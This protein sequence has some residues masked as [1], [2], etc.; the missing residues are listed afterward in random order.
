MEVKDTAG[1]KVLL[2]DWVVRQRMNAKQG[3]GRA[4]ALLSELI[5][6]EKVAAQWKAFIQAEKD[7]RRLRRL[8]DEPDIIPPGGRPA[9]RPPRVMCTLVHDIPQQYALPD[10]LTLLRAALKIEMG[11]SAKNDMKEALTP[12]LGPTPRCALLP[13][14]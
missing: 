10:L 12:S 4:A 13:K 3:E 14:P 6:V 5:R 1:G 2:S 11:V 9:L 7:K 8:R